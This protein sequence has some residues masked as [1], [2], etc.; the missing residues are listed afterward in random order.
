MSTLV[1]LCICLQTLGCTLR[2]EKLLDT[3]ILHQICCIF[4]LTVVIVTFTVFKL[5]LAL[6]LREHILKLSLGL[7]LFLLEELLSIIERSVDDCQG[8]VKKEES[9][10]EYE[11]Q[12][13]EERVISVHPLV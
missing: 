13:E 11:R 4:F 7:S 1:L 3:E 5:Y 8:E 12:K 2:Y 6:L 9:A 10:Y